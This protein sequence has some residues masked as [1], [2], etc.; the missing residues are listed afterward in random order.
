MFPSLASEHV[1]YGGVT[2]TIFDGKFSRTDR[3]LTIANLQGEGSSQSGGSRPLPSG[4]PLLSRGV[5]HV[6]L[7][8]PEPEMRRVYASWVVARVQYV[9]A[10]WKWSVLQLITEAVSQ[11]QPTVSPPGTKAAIASTRYRTSPK[12]AFTWVGPQNFLPKAFGGRPDSASITTGNPTV[13]IRRLDRKDLLTDWAC[14]QRRH[15]RKLS[16]TGLEAMALRP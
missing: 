10:C 4:E 11:Q 9:Q 2:N 3:S 12:P 1:V 7:V 14:P 6:V 13:Q 16:C 15:S 5:S 8:C